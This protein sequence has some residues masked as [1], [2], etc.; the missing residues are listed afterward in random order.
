MNKVILIG[1]LT[2][3]NSVR[4]T[5]GG[6]LIVSNCVAC[7]RDKDTTDFIEI[8]AFGKTADLLKKYFSKGNKIGLEGEL[9]M[10]AYERKDGTKTTKAQVL[11][12]KLEFLEPKKQAVSLFDGDL[13]F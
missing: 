3:D 8:V 4:Q 11:V 10:T 2:R 5:E 1:R 9:R 12:N 13:P 7:V 6:Q